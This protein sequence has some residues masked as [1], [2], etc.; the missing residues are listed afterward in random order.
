MDG[1]NSTVSKVRVLIADDDQVILRVLDTALADEG[2]DPITAD[3]LD[4][5]IRIARSEELDLILLDVNFPEGNATEI[6]QDLLQ[7]D[8]TRNVIMLTGSTLIKDAVSAMKRGAF[9]YIQKPVD[10]DL[11]FSAMRKAHDMVKAKREILLLKKNLR[12]QYRFQ[13]IIGESRPMRQLFDNMSHLVDKSVTVLLQ[14][15]SGTGKELVAKAIHY[16]STRAKAP[17]VAVN[18]AAIPETLLESELF[19]HEKGAFTGATGRQLGK[20]EQAQ[21]GTIFLDEIAE[22]PM[23]SQSRLLR[24]LQEREIERLGGNEVIK[25]DVRVI[26]ATNRRLLEMVE[27]KTFRDDLYYRLSVFP[28]VLPPLRERKGDIP[29]LVPYLIYKLREDTK[30]TA[31]SINREALRMLMAYDWPGNVRELENVI[32]RALILADGGQLDTSHLPIELVQQYELDDEDEYFAVRVVDQ[33]RNQVRPFEDIERSVIEQ[34]LVYNK[35]NIAATAE[36]LALGRATL[37]RKIKKYDLQVNPQSEANI[38]A[39][40]EDSISPN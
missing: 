37:Y 15:E 39:D 34:A 1:A 32:H 31:L 4:D 38:E 20:F 23:Q 30:N 12:S 14:A 25:I 18:C 3:T 13:N 5:A 19:G 29:L 8:Q 24:V 26:A 7:P 6:I 22:M 35:G 40:L 9:D 10:Y 27:E 21:G 36:Q 28:L 11:M 16:N 2:Y 33:S 17:F